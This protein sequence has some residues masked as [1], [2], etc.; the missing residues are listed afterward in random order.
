[1]DLKKKDW[2]LVSVIT[3]C[4]NSGKYVVEALECVQRQNYPNLQHILIDDCSTDDSAAVL[5]HWI[6]ENNYSCDFTVHKVNQGVQS[7]LKE[8]FAKVKGK[9]WVGISDDLWVE[10]RLLEDVALF[11][12]LDESYAMIY[13]DTSMIDKDNNI[14]APSM[15]EELRGKNY[16]P[17]TG[18]IFRD[19]VFDF[20]FF[21][22]SSII[23]QKHF[24]EMNYAFSDSIISEDWAWQLWLSRNYKVLGLPQVRSY[25]RRLDTS[26]TQTNWTRDRKHTVLISHFE[27]MAPYYDHPK[28]TDEEKL[29]IYHRLLRI[30]DDISELPNFSRKDELRMM[31]NLFRYT[32][33]RYALR[34]IVRALITGRTRPESTQIASV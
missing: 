10:N 17:P 26:I 34:R 7:S 13:G 27:M 29:I 32:R 15:F 19:V 18:N 1:M 24:L 12:S 30:Y 2:P 21:I 9:Y 6:D 3:L 5:K 16:T 11:E 25:Y 23:S 31:W 20:Y 28:N 4:Y 33:K 14:I 8:A 22:Q